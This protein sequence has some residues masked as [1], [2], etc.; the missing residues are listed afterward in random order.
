ML[1]TYDE[2]LPLILGP[3]LVVQ[4]EAPP[5][6]PIVQVPIP[7]G[8]TPV[9]PVTVAVNTRVEPGKPVPL[10]VKATP[11][12]GGALEIFVLIGEVAGREV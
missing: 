9:T 3:D 5:V 11:P 2:V 7:I 12:T 10:P 1:Q 8:A 6:P 4:L